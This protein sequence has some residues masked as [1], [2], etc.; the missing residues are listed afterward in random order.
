MSCKARYQLRVFECVGRG[1]IRNNE[2]AN[3]QSSPSLSL[4]VGW[5]LG[6]DLMIKESLF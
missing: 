6:G 4:M 3:A 5:V 1:T 2:L